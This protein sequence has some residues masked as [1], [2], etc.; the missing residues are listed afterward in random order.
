MVEN[1][2]SS[3]R[4][5]AA[6]MMSGGGGS[7]RRRIRGILLVA[8]SIASGCVGPIVHN[9]TELAPLNQPA[10]HQSVVVATRSRYLGDRLNAALMA[11]LQGTVPGLSVYGETQVPPSGLSQPRRL[12]LFRVQE[13]H[14]HDEGGYAPS[15]QW[16]SALAILIIPNIFWGAARQGVH[17]T[18]ELEV[19][20]LDLKSTP[21]M[22]EPKDKGVAG[23]RYDVRMAPVVYRSSHI[24]ELDTAVNY[25]RSRN[26]STTVT[27]MH[28][29]EIAEEMANRI[30]ASAWPALATALD[31]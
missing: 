18:M 25:I 24:V 5:R 7:Y 3:D 8:A 4:L 20:V 11:R 15:A 28:K 6:P 27:Q 17:H 23:H 30:L 14:R 1:R 31:R 21:L 19:R 2:L 10:Q 9:R 13:W 12:V 16:L 22:K 29:T 26:G